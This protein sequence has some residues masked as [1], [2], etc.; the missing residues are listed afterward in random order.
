MQFCSHTDLC[1]LA[2]VHSSLRDA[3]ERVIYSDIYFCAWPFDLIQDQTWKSWELKEDKSLLHTLAYNIRKAAMVKV[4]YIEFEQVGMYNS[5][6][7]LH[8]ILVKLS[9]A[10]PNM[11]NLVDLRVVYDDM[12]VEPSDGVFSRAIRFVCSTTT[13]DHIHW[14]RVWDYRGGYFKLD[15][16]CLAHTH[17][18]EGII[19]DQP[20]LQLLGVYYD[21]IPS[22]RLSQLFQSIVSRHH[23]MPIFM[24]DCS[25]RHADLDIFPLSHRP[26]KAHQVCQDIAI[27]LRKCP[28]GYYQQD[29]CNLTFDLFGITAE[30]ISLF[31][32][33]AEAMAIYL[34]NCPYLNI[35][36][37]EIAQVR[38]NLS[39]FYPISI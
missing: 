35:T 33:A 1:S 23:T 8:S 25:A 20:H 36:I 30:N 15:T 13:R 7:T 32:E 37:H 19:V 3:A 11:S 39:Q 14:Y 28:R 6:E 22:S 31:H 21:S 10:L 24:L 38:T 5:K 4:L 12:M 17:D 18:L 16:L 27:S 2:R 26:G 34:N 29:A 9:E